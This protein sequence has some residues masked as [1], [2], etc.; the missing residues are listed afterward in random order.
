MRTTDKPGQTSAAR[1]FDREANTVPMARSWVTSVYADFDASKE[2]VDVCALLVSEV[3]TNAV[4]HGKGEKYVVVVCPD[5]WIEVWDEAPELP[6]RR[7]H[8]VDSTFGRGI[9]LL[10]MLAPGYQVVQDTTR[11]GKEVRFLPRRWE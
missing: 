1:E 5:L 2:V 11:G 4:V 10:E 7:A 3:V 9:E 6:H 8:A